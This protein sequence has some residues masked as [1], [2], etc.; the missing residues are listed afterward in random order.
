MALCLNLQVVYG[1]CV[2]ERNL[3]DVVQSG[4]LDLGRQLLVWMHVDL[5]F[6]KT[7]TVE[8]LGLLQIL[9]R[10][11]LEQRI[12]VLKLQHQNFTNRALLKRPHVFPSPTCVKL[13]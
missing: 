9:L 4:F 6:V 5:Y 2:F 11:K 12:L 7:E 1:V 13:F 10:K 3:L 8:H